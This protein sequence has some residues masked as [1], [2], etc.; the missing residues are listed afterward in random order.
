VVGS[1]ALSIVLAMT[2]LVIPFGAQTLRVTVS[3]GLVSLVPDEFR[4]GDVHYV[5]SW[6]GRPTCG[7]FL[8]SGAGPPGRV[9]EIV[10]GP[11]SDAELRR[12]QDGMLPAPG[13]VQTC[14]VDPL[15]PERGERYNG[16]EFLMA[17]R[18]AWYVVGGAEPDQP[19]ISD[20]VVFHVR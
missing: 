8:A 4:E 20:F 11:L 6:R 3:D 17:G 15:R 5:V 18:Y 9:G 10:R 13:G 2:P 1:S 12:I 7:P 16:R 19:P 14:F